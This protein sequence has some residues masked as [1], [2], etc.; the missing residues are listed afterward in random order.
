MPG[1]TMKLSLAFPPESTQKPVLNSIMRDYDLVFNIL[2]A[3]IQPGLRGSMTVEVSGDAHRIQDAIRYLEEQGI[4]VHVYQNAIARDEQRCVQC[5][6]CVA[7]CPSGA[8]TLP[9]DTAELLFDNDS[10]VV[11][12][13]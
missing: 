1:S 5:G 12:G 3:Q 6:A 13:M 9:Y 10:C 2:N 7:V 8:L 11:C 4:I